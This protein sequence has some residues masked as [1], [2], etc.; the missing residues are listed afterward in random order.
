MKVNTQ[1]MKTRYIC[2]ATYT[3]TQHKTGL[4]TLKL[5]VVD[6]GGGYVVWTG[7]QG[8]GFVVMR[9]KDFLTRKL[10]HRYE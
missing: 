6:D 5:L 10:F 9:L 2:N 1:F 3:N 4:Q 8:R 7:R